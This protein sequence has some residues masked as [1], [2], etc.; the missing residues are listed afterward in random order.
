MQTLVKEHFDSS[1]ALDP[2][3]Y[4]LGPG[5]ESRELH[6]TLISLLLNS[7]LLLAIVL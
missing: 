7:L 4:A 5:Q 1:A 2:P 6:D 3:I